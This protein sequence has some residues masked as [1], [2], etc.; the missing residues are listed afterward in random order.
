[1]LRCSHMDGNNK[2]CTFY[3]MVYMRSNGCNLCVKWVSGACGKTGV[4]ITPTNTKINQVNLI[5]SEIVTST[6]IKCKDMLSA[7]LTRIWC[8]IGCA[9]LCRFRPSFY[10]EIVYKM[11]QRCK[12]ILCATSI[13]VLP[14]VRFLNA[15]YTSTHLSPTI[16]VCKPM[17][18]TWTCPD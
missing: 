17:P 5:Q 11:F 2:I 13:I 15:N 1:M 14:H 12:R 6:A 18:S 9:K 10:N 8:K 4:F 7:S 3:G 16:T